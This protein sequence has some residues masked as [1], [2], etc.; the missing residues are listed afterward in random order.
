[1][2]KNQIFQHY[3]QNRNQQNQRGG[4]GGR[5]RNRGGRDRDNRGNQGGGNRGNNFRPNRGGQQGGGGG[6]FTPRPT[7]LAA[8]APSPQPQTTYLEPQSEPAVPDYEVLSSN[9]NDDGSSES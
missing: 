4:R 2:Q 8:Q 5:D 7:Q 6:V 1:M 3:L 9:R